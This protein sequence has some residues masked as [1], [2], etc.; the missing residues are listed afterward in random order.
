MFSSTRPDT[1]FHKLGL[2]AG[3]VAASGVLAVAVM[4]GPMGLL[5]SGQ[6]RAAAIVATPGVTTPAP[7]TSTTVAETVPAERARPTVTRKTPPKATAPVT[8]P[9]KPRPAPVHTASKVSAPHRI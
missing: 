7:V 4:A 3:F 8:A 1:A 6:D 9:S 5:R 2:R